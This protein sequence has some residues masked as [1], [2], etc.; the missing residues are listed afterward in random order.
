[1]QN[2]I[3]DLNL[4]K[5]MG[6]KLIVDLTLTKNMDVESKCR[7]KFEQKNM[8][9]EGNCQYEQ[10]NMCVVFFRFDFKPCG[11]KKL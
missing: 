7:F 11:F 9:E 3:L 8:G 10:K 5:N 6:I 4:Y 2:T 1:M